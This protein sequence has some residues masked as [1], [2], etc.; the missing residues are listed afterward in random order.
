M[1]A[2][3]NGR[4]RPS[5]RTS[6]IE[7]S[8]LPTRAS[9]RPIGMLG[10]AGIWVGIAVIIATYSLGAAG[11][12]GGFSLA[13]VVLTIMAANL[14]IGLFMILTADIGTEHG[15]SF[16]VYLRAPFGIHGTHLP[17]VSRGLVAAMWFGIQTYLGALALNGIGEHFFGFSNWF[18]WYLAFGVLQVGNTMLGI[19]SVDAL[20][21]WL[22][23]RSSRFPPGCTFRWKAWPKPRA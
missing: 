13:T 3:E 1:T 17:A 15:L 16:A 5:D 6:L 9:Q 7:E 11:I 23:R 21:R 12:G 19:K 22:R 18:V 10:Y 2:I 14:A 4:E 20:P 8:I